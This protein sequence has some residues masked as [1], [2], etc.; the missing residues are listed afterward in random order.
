MS[1]RTS[2]DARRTRERAAV[3]ARIVATAE[4]IVTDEGFA[5]LT[6]RRVASDMEYAAPIV[7]QHFA[8]KAALVGELVAD[9]YRRLTED[10]RS[11]P[12]AVDPDRRLLDV[13]VAYVRFAGAHPHLYEA[14]NG[15]MVAVDERR[16]AAEATYAL[17][18]DLLLEWSDRRGVNLEDVTDACEVIWGALYGLASLGYLDSI[19]NERAQQLAVMALGAILRGWRARAS[20]ASGR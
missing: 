9:G 20:D 14:M 17:L 7:Y 5:A 19:G 18:R 13:A 6:M 1:A 16:A 2:A 15:G 11:V 8:N 10:L 12:G 4:Q 3:R